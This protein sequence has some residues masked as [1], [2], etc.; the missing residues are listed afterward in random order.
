MF[1]YVIR[2]G[3]P[4]YATDSLT[5]NGVKQADALA[6]RMKKHGV[7]EIYCSPLGRAVQTAQPTCD[8][9]KLPKTIE[10]WMS[11]DL[12][13]N[14]LSVDRGYGNRDWSFGCQN[15]KLIEHD[16]TFK[17]WHKN[18]VFKTCKAPLDGYNRVAACSDEF[19]ARL[20]Y[21][22]EGNIYKVVSPSDKRI[23]AFCHHGFGTTWLSHLLS[24]PPHIL[25]SSFDIAHSTVTILVFRNNPDGYTAPQCMCLSDISH[26]YKEDLPLH[27]GIEFF[28]D[29]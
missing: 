5:E 10:D 3:E 11:E 28:R 18:P 23:A 6:E 20:G 9:L 7:D 15:T 13:F 16:Y 21:E 24:I 26:I 8:L 17:N 25:W 12:V 1:L 2:H 14:E 29:A 19:L 27:A 4:D 22:R